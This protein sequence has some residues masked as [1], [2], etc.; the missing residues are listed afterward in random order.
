MRLLLTPLAAIAATCLLAIPAQA[1]VQSQPQ[2]ATGFVEIE[3]GRLAYET[4]GREGAAPVVLLHDGV[5]G[6]AGFDAVWPSLCERYRVLRYD[7][8]GF[9]GSTSAAASYQ[10][11]K[12]LEAVIAALGIER[13]VLVGSSAGGGLAV[14]YALAHPDGVARL[15]LVGPS[16]AGFKP[17]AAFMARGMRLMTLL[18]L[19]DIEG[20][21]RDPYILTS[22]A[23]AERAHVVALLKAHPGNIGAGTRERLAADAKPRLA[24]IKVPTLILVGAVDIEDVH[25]QAKALEA[26]I[27]GA[28]RAIVEDS[29]HFLY[30]ERPAAFVEALN[31]FTDGR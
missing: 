19:G 26:A 31:A 16:V 23:K 11:L 10:P 9:G 30:L 2:T 3:G 21:A 28:R 14:D 24:E 18:K 27:P 7:R 20:A 17:S 1:Q 25:E 15:V 12:D 22:K 29:G 8:R 5:L 13:P 4:C 6:S